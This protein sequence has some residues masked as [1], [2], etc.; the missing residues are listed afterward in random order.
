MFFHDT[1]V[2]IQGLEE[3][4]RYGTF[5]GRSHPLLT[6]LRAPWAINVIDTEAKI[7]NVPWISEDEHSKHR[8]FGYGGFRVTDHQVPSTAP[9]MRY[10]CMIESMQ[11]YP[12]EEV[13][14]L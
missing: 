13:M 8:T 2:A 5:H 6:K 10:G 9:I 1:R 4:P 7:S 12:V 14:R 3:L 11:Q